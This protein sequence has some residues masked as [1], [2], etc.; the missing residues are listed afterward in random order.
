V[1]GAPAV[2]LVGCTVNT[3]LFAAAGLMIKEAL[4]CP[5]SPAAVVVSV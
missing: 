3:S 2:T 4:G 5:V 1:I